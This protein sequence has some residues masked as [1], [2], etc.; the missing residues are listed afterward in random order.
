[1][2]I[3]G[4]GFPEVKP[5]HPPFK[6][7]WFLQTHIN[8]FSQ[9][10][11][12]KIKVII[13]IGSWYGS[14]TKWLAERSPSSAKIYAIDLWDDKFIIQDDHY[15]SNKYDMLR[16]H[17]LYPTFLVNMWQY[18]DRVVPLRMDAVAGLEHLKAQ[19]VEPDII[20][21]DADHHYEAVKRDIEACMKLFPNAILV[22]DDYGQ[23]EGVRQ[24]VHECAVATMRSGTVNNSPLKVPSFHFC[25]SSALFSIQF[26]PLHLFTSLLLFFPLIF[27]LSSPLLDCT[28]SS[29]SSF[30]RTRGPPTSFH[31]QSTSTAITVGPTPPCR[32]ALGGTFYQSLRVRQPSGRS[33]TC[34]PSTLPKPQ[35]T[36]ATKRVAV[37]HQRR[38]VS[39]AQNRSLRR[40]LHRLHSLYP[41]REVPVPA[42]VPAPL[43]LPV[44]APVLVKVPL[45]AF[46]PVPVL[47]PRQLMSMSMSKWRRR[48]RQMHRRW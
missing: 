11:T 23:Y 15:T 43:V 30:W 36:V 39:A 10:I 27:S 19:G 6:H 34:W 2:Q 24:A 21:I 33:L 26:S 38:I 32:P 22:G 8:V 28:S 18:R 46:V 13:E 5:A 1:M 14:S 37:Y 47:V 31:V 35:K 4:V 7:G 44:R 20:Y 40:P 9:L 16:D 17:P 41:H 12:P 42:L 29:L 25:R 3:A 48:D 45:Q